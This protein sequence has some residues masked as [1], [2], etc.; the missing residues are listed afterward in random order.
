MGTKAGV[1]AAWAPGE[2]EEACAASHA[3]STSD[4]NDTTTDRDP[5]NVFDRLDGPDQAFSESRDPE[6]GK[7]RT[8]GGGHVNVRG[9]HGDNTWVYL[10]DIQS[11]EDPAD[12]S[13]GAGRGRGETD[14]GPEGDT[15]D[16]VIEGETWPMAKDNEPDDVSSGL[17]AYDKMD[18]QT[19]ETYM[20]T[21]EPEQTD[22]T[23]QAASD[24][25]AARQ[26]E[27]EVISTLAAA[28]VQC[29]QLASQL[30][31]KRFTHQL[32]TAI[33][34]ANE[35]DTALGEPQPTPRGGIRTPAEREAGWDKRQLS[36]EQGRVYLG[37]YMPQ[38]PAT[39]GAPHAVAATA[40]VSDCH[41]P[42]SSD[43]ASSDGGDGYWVYTGNDY[44]YWTGDPD[45]Q[46][47]GLPTPPPSSPRDRPD[48]H[49]RDATATRRPETLDGST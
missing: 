29:E 40:R 39:N 13:D 15:L 22:E 18:D 45:S 37:V 9:P 34:K 46:S 5:K 33:N 21:D 35:I 48:A 49:A 11:I 27:K 42:P 10:E 47:E 38:P 44:G 26:R 31:D 6:S 19:D 24:D 8:S 23:D 30:G 14:P 25:E 32:R 1:D 36:D 43:A 16:G 4:M 3:V 28:L 20:I 7:D 12:Q 41:E 17:E 2:G